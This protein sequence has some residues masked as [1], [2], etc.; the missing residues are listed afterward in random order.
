MKYM[1]VASTLF[2]KKLL[3]VMPYT[4][5]SNEMKLTHDAIALIK[6]YE[7]FSAEP[8]ICPGDIW[9]IGYGHTRGVS[10]YTLPI[11]EAQAEML[12]REDVR[13]AEKIVRAHVVVPLS[14]GQYGALVSFVFNVGAGNFTRSTLLKKLNAGDYMGAANELYRWVFA[15]GRKLRGLQRRRKAERKMFLKDPI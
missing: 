5:H 4:R 1:C 15:S 10:S 9:T 6:A 2:N 12:L 13:D 11:T 8:Y 3:P 14:N 7:G